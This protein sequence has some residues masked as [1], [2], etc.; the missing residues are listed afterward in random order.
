MINT[1]PAKPEMFFISETLEIT[2]L[3]LS[4][5]RE[6][7]IGMRWEAPY[8]SPFTVMVSSPDCKSDFKERIPVRS[9]KLNPVSQR[10]NDFSREQSPERFVFLHK[11]FMKITPHNPFVR[12]IIS[13]EETDSRADTVN[14]AYALVTAELRAQPDADCK[15]TAVGIKAVI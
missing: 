11:A 15:A 7:A 8:F 3:M 2:V 12:G 4:L 14:G 1:I 10:H 6:P 5:K 13:K 9:V